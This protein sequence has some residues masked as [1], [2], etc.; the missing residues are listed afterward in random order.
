MS[1]RW[2]YIGYYN[3]NN[4]H[5]VY[6]W[7]NGHDVAECDANDCDYNGISDNP[8]AFCNIRY[9]L[10]DDYFNG[11]TIA[12]VNDWGIVREHAPNY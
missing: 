9:G 10:I 2:K 8:D 7:T 3:T 5:T 4:Y 1:A 12:W 6:C 11:D